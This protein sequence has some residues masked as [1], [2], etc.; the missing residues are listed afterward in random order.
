MATNSVELNIQPIALDAFVFLR[1]KDNPVKSLTIDQV[2]DI[3]MP[4]ENNT[5]IIG[6]RNQ[7]GR[8][9]RVNVGFLVREYNTGIISN[10]LQIGGPDRMIHP[11]VRNRNSGSQETMQNLVMNG[12]PT[13]KGPSMET[14]TMMGPYNSLAEDTTGIGFTFFYYQRYMSPNIRLRPSKRVIQEEHDEK[15]TVKPIQMFALDGVLPS[16]KSIAD[17]TYLLVT[18]VYVVT[19]KDLEKDHPAAQLRDWLVSKEGQGVIG[20]TGYVP[21]GEKGIAN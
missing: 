19:R 11:Y 7:V 5:G 2:R 18:E 17:R 15:M 4:V 3:F 10:W 21:I 14:M 13:V 12:Q 9:V 1:Q 6:N 8:P 20:E 16:Y